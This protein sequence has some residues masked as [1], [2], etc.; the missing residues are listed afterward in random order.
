MLK[1]LRTIAAVSL[2]IGTA[3]G[4]PIDLDSGLVAYLPL[5]GSAADASGNGN[6]GTVVGL[7]PTVDR[8]GNANSAYSFEKNGYIQI[9]N[10]LLLNGATTASITGWFKNRL[11]AGEA[12]FVVGAGDSRAGLDPFVLWMDGAKVGQVFFFDSFK[13]PHHPDR[14]IGFEAPE[15]RISMPQD[16]WI[17]F[18]SQFSSTA[19]HSTY[20]LYLNGLL[21][22]RIEY[23]RSAQAAFDQ[24]MPVQIGALTSF[25]DSQFRGEIDEIRFYNRTLSTDEVAVLAGVP[26]PDM[27][28]TLPMLAGAVGLIFWRSRQEFGKA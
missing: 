18:V 15:E 7:T 6:D 25:Q 14:F 12:G 22:R 16:E 2:F 20:E 3:H 17:H 28:A 24:P 4:T 8:F 27:S 11:R 26:V 21:A 1:R 5:D 13:G 9:G 23:D 10:S 19:E